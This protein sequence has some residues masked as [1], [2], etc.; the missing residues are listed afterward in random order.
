MDFELGNILVMCDTEPVCEFSR[1]NP[2]ATEPIA[3]KADLPPV[4]G[5]QVTISF[6]MP[7]KDARRM[8]AYF[9]QHEAFIWRAI[10]RR[11]GWTT[12]RMRR[13]KKSNKCS[14]VHDN[15]GLL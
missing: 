12:K 2:T 8:R 4:P 13:M 7:R 9:E 1:L 11:F 10:A 5:R 15:P 14:N 6:T 3:D